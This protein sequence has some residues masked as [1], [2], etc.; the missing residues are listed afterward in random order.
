MHFACKIKFIIAVICEQC[1][2]MTFTMH[3]S[4]IWCNIY[5]LI[6]WVHIM[7]EWSFVERDT[8]IYICIK[9]CHLEWVFCHTAAFDCLDDGEQCTVMTFVMYHSDIWC[10]IYHLIVWVHIM[11]E[12]SF[13]ERDTFI[14]ICIKDCHLEWVFCHT[15]AF[16]CLDDGEQCTVM[17][18]VMY[19]SDIWCDI[20]HL[21]VWV[22]IML[23]VFA[24]RDTF[25]Y[26]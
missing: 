6:V 8:F 13:V 11:L 24:E 20:H 19:H 15:A 10:D 22:H 23:E 14:Y 3:H 12:W 7:L 18:F 9:D 1:T 2:V 16:D 5:H 21:I 4:D 26:I 25:I 17:T